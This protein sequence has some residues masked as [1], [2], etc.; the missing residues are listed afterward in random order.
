MA[1]PLSCVAGILARGVA[2]HS[3]NVGGQDMRLA[4]RTLRDP[5]CTLRLC[6]EPVGTL[7][8]SC[9]IMRGGEHGGAR[10]LA[11]H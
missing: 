1:R 4:L 9:E 6:E 3:K 11:R 8:W 10:R 7:P 5:N 2:R